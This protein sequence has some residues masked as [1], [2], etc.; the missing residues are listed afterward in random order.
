VEGIPPA[1][2]VGMRLVPID[3]ESFQQGLCPLVGKVEVVNREGIPSDAAVGIR[4]V[5][6]DMES[7][8]QGSCPLVGKVE[9]VN[10]GETLA[11]ELCSKFSILCQG[12]DLVYQGSLTVGCHGW[13]GMSPRKPQCLQVRSKCQLRLSGYK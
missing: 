9:V 4:L 6:I 11:T 7:L 3:I 1:A 13:R 2:V 5:P 8:Q 10:R 12:R